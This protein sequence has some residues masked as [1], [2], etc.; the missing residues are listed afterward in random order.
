MY[1]ESSNDTREM[2]LYTLIVLNRLI[3]R[4]HFI[5]VW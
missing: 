1:F 5:V 3:G 2:I 4:K